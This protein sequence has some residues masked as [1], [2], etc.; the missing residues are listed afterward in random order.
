MPKGKTG[1]TIAVQLKADG[2]PPDVTARLDAAIKKTLLSELAQLD[3]GAFTNVRLKGP[4]GDG[5][6]LGILVDL[7]GF[8]AKSIGR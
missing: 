1:P 3:V 6:P 5:F 8:R 4:F 2:L 7:E